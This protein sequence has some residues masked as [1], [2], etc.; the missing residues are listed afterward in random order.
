MGKGS[1]V[2]RLTGKAA[3]V[4]GTDQPFGVAC[5]DLMAGEGALVV[6][7]GR[8]IEHDVSDDASW[9]RVI[10]A[11]LS[12]HG[13]L[14]ILLNA[15][16]VF[17]DKPL[18]D[19]TLEELRQ[20]EDTNLLGAWLGVK[21]GIMAM[22]QSGGGSIVTVSSALAKVGHPGAAAACAAAGGVRIM[23]QAA[24]LECGVR[25]DGIRVNT[26]LAG[27]SGTAAEDVARAVLHVVSDDASFMTGS[28]LV[29]GGGPA[30]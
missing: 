14:D 2:G 23:T 10:A 28:D 6:G 4:T 24:A 22:R 11:T 21:H 17:L 1:T 16:Q 30:A 5:A 7:A 26:V 20:I 15:A 29:V 12:D 19:T 13:Q 18:V 9:Q 8:D 25:G 27:P 3:I